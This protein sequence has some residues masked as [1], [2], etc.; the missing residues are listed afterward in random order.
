MPTN[1]DTI[2]SS[3]EEAKEKLTFEELQDTL[4]FARAMF[5]DYYDSFE[6]GTRH[7]GD[8]WS[9]LTPDNVNRALQSV[10]L[11]PERPTSKGIEQALNNPKDNEDK[12]KNFSRH[13]EIKNMLYKRLL[14]YNSNM[15]AW[16]WE[17]DTPS[18]DIKEVG[19][20]NYNSDLTIIDDTM[21]R[22]KLKGNGNNIHKLVLAQG[23]YFGV[24]RDEGTDYTFQELPS[25]YCKI[26]GRSSIGWLF[27]FD[28]SYFHNES[29]ADIN[30]FPKAFKKLYKRVFKQISDEYDPSGRVLRKRH[31]SYQYWVSVSPADNFFCFTLDDTV[32]NAIPYYSAIFPELETQPRMRGLEE[33][34]ALI[35]ASKVLVGMLETYEKNRNNTVSGQFTVNPADVGKFVSLAKK[36]LGDIPLAVLP[37][38]GVEV[39]DFS[40]ESTDR[41]EEWSTTTASLATSASS[42]LMSDTSL[43]AFEAELSATVDINF[44]E[45]IYFQFQKFLDYYVNKKTEHYRFTFTLHDVKTQR[46][47]QARMDT[48]QTMASMGIVDIQLMARV[49]DKNV[50][51]ATRSLKLTQALGLEDM[52]TS[53]QSLNN[54]TKEDDVGRPS[55]DNSTNDSTN[56]SKESGS[57][58]LKQV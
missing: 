34:K 46:N 33:D 38:K 1:D 9:W 17:F 32:A 52:L 14:N 5:V 55:D 15:L 41:Y 51:Q 44:A 10:N 28:F 36:S 19:S 25:K 48:F 16:N 50:F 54:Q 53:L 2:V 18:I 22:L 35:A 39:V 3:E 47:Q 57:N 56:A 21:S 37:V 8:M 12:L 6:R 11:N 58:D 23:I 7:G 24:L 20:T 27:D 43:N 30:M 42:V 4:S 13:F 40:V 29:G 49:F 26:T 45:M 31:S